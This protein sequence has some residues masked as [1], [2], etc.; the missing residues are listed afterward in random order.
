MWSLALILVTI[1]CLV[2]YV[3]RVNRILSHH[4]RPLTY[5][6]DVILHGK[7]A[8]I[9]GANSG[10]GKETAL[11]LAG[12][13]S[14]VILACR[15]LIKARETAEEIRNMTGNP[16]IVTIQLDLSDLESVKKCAQQINQNENRFVCIK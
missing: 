13:G 3:N 14:K 6:S 12:R 1:I 16:N 2:L 7:T 11:D 9:T 4:R 5:V 15:D 8:L 10:I